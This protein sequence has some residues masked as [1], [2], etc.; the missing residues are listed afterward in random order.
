[1][2]IKPN[3]NKVARER[4]V[5][6]KTVPALLKK[7]G[8]TEN[9]WEA[10]YP[11]SAG[12]T[13]IS[14]DF[15]VSSN[16]NNTENAVNLIIDSKKDD[17]NLESFIKQVVSYGRLIKAKYS[18]LLNSAE[19]IVIDNNTASKLFDGS[20]TKLSKQFT[21]MF[22]K[23]KYFSKNNIVEFSSTQ[24]SEAKN[25]LTI[26]EDIKQLNKVLMECQDIIRDCDGLTG[27][28][29][30]DELSKVL[31]IKIYLENQNNSNVFSQVKMIEN[32]ADGIDWSAV[33]FENVKKEYSLLFSD[34]DLISLS[35]KA[36]FEIVG[37]LEKYDFQNTNVDIKGNAYEILLG[38]TFLGA[39]GQ[40]FTPRTVVD[41]MLNMINPAGMMNEKYIPT[42]MDPSCGTGGFLVRCLEQYLDK[43]NNLGF[44][45]TAKTKIRRETIFGIDLNPRSAKV[46]K[47]NMSLHGD[48]HG[49]I[50]AGN[51]LLPPKGFENKKYDV[52]LTNPPFGV[53]VKDKDILKLYK[54]GK[55]KS[56]KVKASADSTYL[57]VEHCINILNENGKIGILLPNG[58][59]NNSSDIS[60]RED[61]I[62]SIFVDAM[63]S[64]PARSFKFAKANACT[65]ILFANKSA[66]SN[67]IFMAMPEEIG[68][69]RV[70]QYAKEIP[71]N[72]LIPILQLYRDFCVNKE[73]YKNESSEI[74]VLSKKPVAFLLR[75]DLFTAKRFD[76]SYYYSEYVYK[77]EISENCVRLSEYAV[78]VNRN[79]DKISVP[80]KYVETSNI[81]PSI[82]SICDC[83]IIESDDKRPSRAKL[84]IKNQDI[85]AARMMDCEKNVAIVSEQ[86]DNSLATNGFLHIAPIPPMTTECLYYLLKSD[87]NS[88]QIRYKSSN[89]IMPS[90]YESEYMNNWVP[91]LTV[92]QIHGI[93]DKIKK[94]I[95]SLQKAITDFD[96]ELSHKMY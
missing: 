25:I 88:N 56:G 20:V 1:M 33:Q 39:L 27:S 5:D 92:Q 58:I 11:I 75:K 26:I 23:S 44:S 52:I 51:G 17:E 61:I 86:Y 59:L 35:W 18:I 91:K 80:I 79:L 22:S 57:F 62:S 72:D 77:N 63:I 74:V 24:I 6:V 94:S 9:D 7:L 40:H 48:G 90:I 55:D 70:T 85:I 49:S 19:Y 10:D 53:S 71:Q 76:A 82:G 31:F 2:S 46:T 96:T 69:E 95:D 41:F 50:F 89:T 3:A 32:K 65:G 83:S 93:T 81:V 54:A 34:D 87:F 38:K 42:V 78:P 47:M 4:N 68:Y 43:A 37:K 73:M 64:L 36:V 45:E 28:D 29:A 15:V 66:E 67:Y 13:M 14:S 60:Y 16:L 30:F 84:Y 12:R 8:Y 21:D